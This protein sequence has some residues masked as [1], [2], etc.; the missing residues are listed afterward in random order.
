MKITRK[1][2]FSN[3]RL[4]E[5]TEIN[6]ELNEKVQKFVEKYSKSSRLDGV[7]VSNSGDQRHFFNF[8][9]TEQFN[10]FIPRPAENLLFKDGVLSVFRESDD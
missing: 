5:L 6:L 10:C 3:F 4:Q 2:S 7:D 9:D 8:P 1:H